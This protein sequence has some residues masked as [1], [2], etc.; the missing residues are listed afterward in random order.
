MSFSTI[1]EYYDTCFLLSL[2]AIPGFMQFILS[3][4]LDNKNDSVSELIPNSPQLRYL[5]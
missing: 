1:S 4:I 2:L 3:L 5:P